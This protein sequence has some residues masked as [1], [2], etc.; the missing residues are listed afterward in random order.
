MR[1][2]FLLS[3]FTAFSIVFTAPALAKGSESIAVVVNEGAITRSDVEER[4][5]LIAISSGLPDNE[6]T[7]SRLMPQIVSSLI[8]EEIRLQ[9]AT[10]NKITV[11]DA[12][13][14]EGFKQ[15]AEQNKFTS[16][17]FT[18]ILK[19][20]GINIKTIQRQIRAQVAWG[21][22]VQTKI[23][24]QINVSD[25]DVDSKFAMIESNKGKN[26]NLLA[27]IFIP[28]N[29]TNTEEKVQQLAQQL[30]ADIRAEKVLFPRVAQQ[31]S[32]SA[33]SANG[34]MLGWVQVGQLAPELD[35]AVANVQPGGITDPVRT[36]S[37]YHILMVRER[38]VFT[39]EHMPARD[40]VVNAIG[41]ERL[42][43]QARRYLMDLK[44]AAYIDN[45]S[46]P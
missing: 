23:R 42:E 13:I 18:E 2:M 14:S 12:E 3:F 21:K 22:L 10:K 4:Y 27:E 6:T 30:V 15:I 32:Q 11:T 40:E 35:Q 5:R 26:E 33:G 29:E 43:R 8:D 39:D 7:R 36:L 38:R 37:G 1:L 17:Q 19:R 28:V 25:S 41:Q 24:P 34:G 16:E 31:F 20:S 46:K 44:S 9:E 45:R